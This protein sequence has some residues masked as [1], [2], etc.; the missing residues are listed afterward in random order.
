MIQKTTG[1]ALRVSPFS[2]TSHVVTWLTQDHGRVTTVVKGAVRPKSLFLGQYDLFYRCE[3][4]FY[5]RERNGVHVMRECSPLDHRP[6]LRRN[7]RAAVCASYIADLALKVSIPGNES[8]SLFG[9][10]NA[11]LDRAGKA[12][13][14][15]V[16]MLRAELGILDAIGLAPQLDKCSAC[17]L[18]LGDD[19][20]C[21]FSCAGGG[22]L[23]DACGHS[24]ARP[25]ST[26]LPY[27]ALNVLR[28]W[29]RHDAPKNGTTT[30][31][32]GGSAH[33]VQLGCLLG[34]F[35]EYHVHSSLRAR[36]IAADLLQ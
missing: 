22:A 8:S 4:L 33:L 27:E 5:S 19:G 31:E 32:A 25:D 1:I 14:P 23:C 20:E 36:R 10:V 21:G 12:S 15:F 13:S 18:P 11:G 26:T 17:G 35:L 2:R 7:W 16:A 29:Q 6:A 34:T 24:H 30:G 3:V 9:A 28:A